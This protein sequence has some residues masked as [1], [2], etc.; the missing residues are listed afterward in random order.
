[1]KSSLM[2]EMML[3]KWKWRETER[4]LSPVH[5]WSALASLVTG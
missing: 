5:Q 2:N 1:M 4:Q 3:K